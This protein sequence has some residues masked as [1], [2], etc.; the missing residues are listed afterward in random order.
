MRYE[1]ESGI[2]LLLTYVIEEGWTYSVTVGRDV[3]VLE[4]FV[5]ALLASLCNFIRAISDRSSRFAFTSSVCNCLS[6]SKR[7]SLSTSVRNTVNISVMEDFNSEQSDWLE[8]VM[9]DNWAVV[10]VV[11]LAGGGVGER[12][13]SGHSV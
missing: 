3:L 11:V 5:E 6:I 1:V 2:S 9:A 10:R 7:D 12:G 13:V 8:R 4:N